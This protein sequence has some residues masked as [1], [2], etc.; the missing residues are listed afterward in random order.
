MWR[1]LFDSTPPAIPAQVL[2]TNCST[3]TDQTGVYIPSGV[4]VGSAS[5]GRFVQRSVTERDAGTTN[6][7]IML[8]GDPTLSQV[9]VVGYV[10][11][12]L[13]L[14]AYRRR[15]ASQIVNTPIAAWMER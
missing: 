15:S 11:N 2:V 13:K 10:W 9:V 6:R 5:S 3:F 14:P 4:P 8:C 1:G 12:A 7:H